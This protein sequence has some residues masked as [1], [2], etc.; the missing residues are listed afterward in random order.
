[1]WMGILSVSLFYSLLWS[2]KPFWMCSSNYNYFYN[3]NYN[4]HNYNYHNNNYSRM[5]SRLHSL[6]IKMF[7][8]MQI[9]DKT[10]FNSK[11]HILP[12]IHCCFQLAGCV[13]YLYWW[14]RDSGKVG[15]YWWEHSCS[16]TSGFDKDKLYSK[17]II[18]L[19]VF[20]SWWSWMVWSQWY[21]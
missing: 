20:Y 21:F 3:N 12:G 8:S 2:C 4:H 1:M 16:N 14:G 7:Q 5:S 15:N 6:G 18:S 10:L 17:T 11:F 13:D 9:W 19:R